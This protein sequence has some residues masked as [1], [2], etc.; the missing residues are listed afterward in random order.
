MLLQLPAGHFHPIA[1]KRKAAPYLA[2]LQSMPIDLAKQDH[3]L[4]VVPFEV[5]WER[6]L[7]ALE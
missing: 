4:E 5:L 6:V 7:E 3:E 2:R 1:V